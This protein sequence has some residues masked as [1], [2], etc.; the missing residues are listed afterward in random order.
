MPSD[1]RPAGLLLPIVTP[2]A[3]DGS[4][5]VDALERLGAELLDAGASGLIALSTTGEPS[6]LDEA[7]Q[8]ATI[9]ACARVCADRGADLVVGAGTNDTRTT[10]AKHEALADVDGVDASLA[11]VPYY[12]RPSEAGIVAHL[13]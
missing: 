7:E 11:V 3:A 10:I 13:Q 8:A 1:Y 12:V 4:V 6:S 2:F 5:D 9:A